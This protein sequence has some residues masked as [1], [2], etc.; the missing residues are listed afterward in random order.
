VDEKV[1]LQNGGITV[2]S[3]RIEI[4]GQ[5]FATRNVG[6]VKVD[7]PGMSR[8][9]ILFMII[10][11]SA[12]AGKAWEVGFFFV[13]VGGVWAYMTL[14]RREL[15]LVAGGGEVLALKT[16]NKVLAEQ[17]RRA[18]AEAISVR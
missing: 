18:I 14:M 17:V 1:F 6:S 16:S 2:T 11:V 10:G 3:S 5:T 4:N 8:L 15:K 13:A 7:E 9:A 12:M